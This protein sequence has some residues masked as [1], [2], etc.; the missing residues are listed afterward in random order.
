M[1]CSSRRRRRR[2]ATIQP[3]T[4]ASSAMHPSTAATM[5]PADEPCDAVLSCGG[6]AVAVVGDT[7][8]SEVGGFEG[9][10]LGDVVRAQV[11][12]QQ[13]VPQA[14]RTIS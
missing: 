8:R 3:T 10:M 14:D 13:V 2:W 4:T 11:T 12:P 5:V 9:V 7:V 1:S 6:V